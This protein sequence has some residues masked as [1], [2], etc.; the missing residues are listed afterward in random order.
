MGIANAISNST[1]GQGIT[2]NAISAIAEALGIG[3]STGADGNGDDGFGSEGDGDNGGESEGGGPGPG[4][5]G[6][7]GI[8]VGGVGSGEGSGEGDGGDGGNNFADGGAIPGQDLKGKDNFKI[9]VSGGEFVLPTDTVDAIGED[10][11]RALVAAT[12]KPI[13]GATK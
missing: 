3:S 12:H 13:R 7:G 5:E 2:S 6:D 4:G 10:V 9:N 8:S 1:T 11:L